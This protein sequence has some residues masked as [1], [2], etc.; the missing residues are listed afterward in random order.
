MIDLIY[1]VVVVAF[2]AL[3]LGYI[4]FCRTL[5]KGGKDEF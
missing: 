3:S 2:F 4:S 1:L 5:Q